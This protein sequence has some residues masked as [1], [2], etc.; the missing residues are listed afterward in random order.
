MKWSC[1]W[2]HETML[3]PASGPNNAPTGTPPFPERKVD[4]TL[5][6]GP[7][8]VPGTTR[9]IGAEAFL[10]VRVE[11]LYTTGC[12]VQPQR[13]GFFFA[14]GLLFLNARARNR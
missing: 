14:T 6:Q 7:P 4:L 13:G 2:S 12:V 3:T 11:Q 1:L 5:R 8:S 10:I 9:G